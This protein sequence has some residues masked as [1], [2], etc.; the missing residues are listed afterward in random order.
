MKSM[1][2]LMDDSEL[3]TAFRPGIKINHIPGTL[4]PIESNGKIK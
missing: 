1:K 4:V 2:K 3:A